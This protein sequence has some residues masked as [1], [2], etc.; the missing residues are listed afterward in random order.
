MPGPYDDPDFFAD[1]QRA[2]LALD[3]EN[4]L[5]E[6]PAIRACLPDLSSL[7]V[8]DLGCGGGQLAHYCAENGAS[9][10][11]AIDLSRRMI[12]YAQHHNAHSSIR[13]VCGPLESV[14]DRPESYDLVVSS[15]VMHYIEDYEETV[16]RVAELLRPGGY[17][18]FST[19]H[20]NITAPKKVRRWVRDGDGNKLHWP[21]DDYLDE[22]PRTISLLPDCSAELWHR[23]MSTTIK[24]FTPAGM[25]LCELVEPT[26]TEEALRVRPSQVAQKRRPAFVIF[27][28]QKTNPSEPMRS[29]VP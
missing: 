25:S 20:P 3:S 7:R 19:L 29:C 28:V 26:C 17:F 6:Q 11:T 16:M 21:L 4:E 8:L 9:S 5:I 23:A 10:V 1:Y 15:L 2:R 14:S 12:E 24:A 13:Y 22:G 27:K 18:I